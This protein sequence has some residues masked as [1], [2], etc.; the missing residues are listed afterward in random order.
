M[1]T[2]QRVSIIA[3]LLMSRRGQGHNPSENSSMKL[4][5][6]FPVLAPSRSGNINQR[7]YNYLQLEKTGI[8]VKEPMVVKVL[9]ELFLAH[10]I[11]Y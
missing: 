8:I 2:G 6:K 7:M 11:I 4:W 9:N 5:F 3:S 10:G 1:L